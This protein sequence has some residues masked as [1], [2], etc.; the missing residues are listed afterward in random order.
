MAKATHKKRRWLKVSGIIVGILMLLVLVCPLPLYAET[1]GEADDLSHYIKVDGKKPKLDGQFMITAVYMSQVNGIGAIMAWLDPTASLM[2][3]YEANGGGSSADNVAINKIYMDSAVNEAK[4]TAYKAA[5]IPYKRSFNG[6][7][8]MAVQDNSNFKKA[9]KVGDTITSVD[10]HHFKSAKGFQDYIRSNKVGSKLTISYER[11]K[12]AKQ[13]TGKSVALA[14]TKKL[15]GIGIAL[16]DDVSVSSARK[17][18]A[19]MGDIGGPSG[20]LMFSLE[21]YDALSNQN[22]AAGRK[23]AGTGT[24]DKDGNVGEIGGIDKKVIVA[25]EAGAKIFFAPY[26]K[27]TK[28]NL[29]LESDGLTNYQLAVKTAKKY[30]PNMKIVPVKTF[31]EAVNYLQ[32][33]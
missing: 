21:M 27:P 18:S 11:N 32:T 4:A 6:I 23:I 13:A 17:V 9:L 28:S 31:T 8:V 24:I 10:N 19:N 7:Y 5:K 15:P 16:T 1:P 25:H 2:T 26:L 22:L 3:S 20:G 30:A 14:G 33:H 29:A 12:K